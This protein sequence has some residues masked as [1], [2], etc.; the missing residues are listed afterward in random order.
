M[1]SWSPTTALTVVVRSN[2]N[3]TY[4][5]IHIPYY[6][7]HKHFTCHILYYMVARSTGNNLKCTCNRDMQYDSYMQ[8]VI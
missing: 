3:I 1:I 5:I 2:G 4:Y 8:S 6:M 7:L